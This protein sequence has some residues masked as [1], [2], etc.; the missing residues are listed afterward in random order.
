MFSALA[1][2][3]VALVSRVP[4][5]ELAKVG[6][7]RLNWKTVGEKIRVDLAPP[8]SDVPAHM[9]PQQDFEETMRDYQLVTTIDGKPWLDKLMRPPGLHHDRPIS[10]FEETMLSPGSYRIQVRFWPVPPEGATW[11][12]ERDSV[13]VIKA[14]EITTL[15]LVDERGDDE[16]GSF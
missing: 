6:V 2:V 13:V 9:R 11:K 14:G 4:N 10:V 15:T 5:G 16:D 7:L 3:L 1:I 12:P 8:N